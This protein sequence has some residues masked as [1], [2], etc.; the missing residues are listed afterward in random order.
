MT[1]QTRL[2]PE[3]RRDV[4][5][6]AAARL[7]RTGTDPLA[8]TRARVAGACRVETSPDTVKHYFTMEELR[9]AAI[10]RAAE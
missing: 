5:I 4:I 10:A 6:D 2:T 9:A 7:I 1:Y 3:D 8:L